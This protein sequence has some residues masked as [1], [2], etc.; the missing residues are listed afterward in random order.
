MPAM[1]PA[2]DPKAHAAVQKAVA[3]GELFRPDVCEKCGEPPRG[4]SKIHAHHADY[5]KPLDVEWL[6]AK[7]HRKAPLGK[8]GRTDLDWRMVRITL[9]DDQWRIMRI[10]AAMDELSTTGL[11][12]IL[13]SELAEKI[14]D[15]LP[16]RFQR[17]YPP[18]PD[19]A[20][21]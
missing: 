13:L 5:S 2:A 8:N 11:L 3:K 16:P 18:A 17:P 9:D 10:R 19:K 7:C 4:K 1:S 15:E 6:C 12:N 14:H 21:T 20:R